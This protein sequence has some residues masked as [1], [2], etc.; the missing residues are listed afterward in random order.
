MS[1][2]LR[3]QPGKAEPPIDERDDF[4]L[5]PPRFAGAQG[6]TRMRPAGPV[7]GHAAVRRNMV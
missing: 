4:M 1:D 6:K 5:D 2:P 7:A 3:H